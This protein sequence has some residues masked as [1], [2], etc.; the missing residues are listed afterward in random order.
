M[1]NFLDILEEAAKTGDKIDGSAF[2]Y[3]PPKSPNNDFA[4]CKTCFMFRPESERCGIFGPDDKVTADQSCGLYLH[5]KPNEDQKCRSTVTPKQ[6]GLVDG[7]VRC[8]NCSWFDGKCGLFKTLMEKLPDVFNLDINVDP[9][10]CCN[11]FQ[12]K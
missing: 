6:A 2:I 3:L 9:K 11:A 1:R 10:G 12:K 8:E 5:G 7:P 4:Q